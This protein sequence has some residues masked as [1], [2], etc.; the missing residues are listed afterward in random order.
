VSEP[1]AVPASEDVDALA[2]VL[3][4]D[5]ADLDVYSRVL[6]D[7]LA[8]A[9]PAGMVEVDRDQSMRDRL[10]GR[11]GVVRSMRIALGDTTLELARGHAGAPVA[12]VARTVR[13]VT[14]SSREVAVDEWTTVL[15]EQLAERAKQSAAARDALA[16]LLGAG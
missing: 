4:A 3:R 1:P 2:A 9:L 15:A 10:A 6:T 12:R 7:S 5:S 8:G 13:G 14:I 16:R 11:P